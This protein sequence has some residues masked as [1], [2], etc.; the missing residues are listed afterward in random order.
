MVRFIMHFIL[1]YEKLVVI[2]IDRVMWK[3][4]RTQSVI[5]FLI[6]FSAGWVSNVDYMCSG[7]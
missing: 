4:I 3:L 6:T 2:Q 7:G 1:I 5:A